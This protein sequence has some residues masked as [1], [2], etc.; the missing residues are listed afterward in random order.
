MTSNYQIFV[1][2]TVQDGGYPHTGCREDCCKEAWK[3]HLLRKNVASIAIIDHHSKKYWIIDITPDFKIQYQMI[4]EYLKDIYNFS[5]IFLTHSHVGHYIGLLELGLE[6]LNTKN[7]P[8]YVMPQLLKFLKKNDS[9]NFLFKSNNIRSIEIEEKHNINLS[10]DL[11][12][13]SFLVPHRNEMSETVGYNIKTKD[14]SIIYI[15]DIDAWSDWDKNIINVVKGNDLI[16]IDGTFY[17]KREL[18][19][20]SIQDV[21]HPSIIESIELFKDLDKINKN[22]IYFTHFN[23]TNIVLNKKSHQ[24]KN[25]LNNNFNVLEDKQIFNI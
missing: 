4:N 24:Y 9:I 11:T 13:S 18:K 1:S 3:N 8:V 6:I 25:L 16:F 23:H 7:I 22:K 10:A 14:N 2:G 12:I 20:R 19:S 17:D 21:P 15:P 5:G